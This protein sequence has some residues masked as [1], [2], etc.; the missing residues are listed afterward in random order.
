M[1]RYMIVFLKKKTKE[2]FF[3]IKVK[4]KGINKRTYKA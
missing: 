4:I 2:I 3:F 1:H